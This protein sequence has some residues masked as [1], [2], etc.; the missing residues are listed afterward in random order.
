MALTSHQRRLLNEVE[1]LFGL[2]GMMVWNIEEYESDRRVMRLNIIRDKLIRGEVVGQYTLIDEFLTDIICNYY[3][4]RRDTDQTYRR[5]WKTK[6]FRIFV[7]YIMDETYLPKKLNIVNAIKAVPKEVR[8]A[9]MRIN[10]VRNDL[11]HSLFPQNRRRHMDAKAPRSHTN[12]K[13]FL[14]DGVPL[15]TIEGFR[16]FGS[17]VDL[18]CAYLEKRCWGRDDRNE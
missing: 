18:A 8:S 5:L 9:I 3:F 14:Y 13:K 17:D 6:H 10:D 7:H 16:K 12:V 1:E 4:H 15:Y 11:A 2:A